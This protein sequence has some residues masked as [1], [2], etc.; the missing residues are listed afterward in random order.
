MGNAVKKFVIV[1]ESPLA[2]EPIDL[3]LIVCPKC[4]HILFTMVESDPGE[5]FCPRCLNQGL[6]FVD[7]TRAR[8]MLAGT[9]V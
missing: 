9:L 2:S 3:P 4:E 7:N 5:L 1:V 8:Y 6:T